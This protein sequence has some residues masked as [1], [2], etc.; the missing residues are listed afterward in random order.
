MKNI[1]IVILAAGRSTRFISSKS[2]LTHDLA[3]LPIIS[4][5]YNT[6]QKISGKSVVVVCNKNNYA[7]LN[8]LLRGCKLVIQ[9][10]QK[11]TA[12]AIEVARPHIKTENFIIL[13]GDV[14]LVTDTSLKKLIRNFNKYNIG[15]MILF[16]SSNPYGYGRVVLK[17]DKVVK[18]VEEIHT[19]K[20]EKLIELCNSGI[21][22]VNKSIFF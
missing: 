22:L 1:T 18:V 9:K 2:K 21:M 7:E 13:F 8:S 16:K 6:A 5:V 11:G 12:D 4:H 17:K 20:S 19:T 15:S 10:S 3:G 14:P